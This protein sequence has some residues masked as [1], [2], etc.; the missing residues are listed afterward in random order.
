M[1]PSAFIIGTAM[2]GTAGMAT[3]WRRR[4]RLVVF[5]LLLLLALYSG[6]FADLVRLGAAG[7]GAILGPLLLG[8]R[9]RFGRPV[10]SRHEGRVLLSLL[11]AASAI[12]PVV[13]GLVPHAVGPLSI[14]RFLFTNIQNVDPQAL[15]SLCSDPAQAKD[16][17]V[18]QLQLR[19]GAGG[20]FMAI[21]PS[22]LLLLLADGLRRGRRFAW[23]GAL[24]IQVALSVLAGIA[25]AGVLQPTTSATGTSEG[26]AAIEGSASSQPLTLALPLLLPAALT[27]VLLATRRLFHVTAPAGTYGRLAVQELVMAGALG[28]IY[29]SSG[30]LLARDFSPV[31][32]SLDFLADLPDRFLPLGFVLDLPPAFFPQSTAAVLVYEGVGVVFW[33]VTGVL[34]LRTFLR[35]AHTRHDASTVRARTIV[36]TWEGSSLS[37][38]T[39][40]PGTC[41]G[42]RPRESP[43]SRT[44]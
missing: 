6:G 15:Q 18:T 20:I 38:M 19:A 42:S 30:L 3:L 7:A 17:A 12:G 26:I 40:W 4:I 5:A 14:L 39:T 22:V 28:I 25:I 24:L 35:E 10:S 44:G 8:R 9:P 27:I 23:A 43:L 37:W 11:I 41:T 2:A 21:L 34:I 16:C 32:G 36:K 33:A 13:A 31:P 1:G 29:V